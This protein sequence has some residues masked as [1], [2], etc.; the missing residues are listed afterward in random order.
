MQT[1]SKQRNWDPLPVSSDARPPPRL[2]A[3]PCTERWSDHEYNLSWVEPHS[4]C[5][6]HTIR[7]PRKFYLSQPL[8]TSSESR[9][10]SNAAFNICRVHCEACRPCGFAE[11]WQERERDVVCWG[12]KR[13]YFCKPCGSTA[14]LLTLVISAESPTLQHFH[15]PSLLPLKN[16]VFWLDCLKCYILLSELFAYKARAV[17]NSP[18]AVHLWYKRSFL[19]SCGNLLLSKEFAR[20]SSLYRKCLSVTCVLRLSLI[21]S[22]ILEMVLNAGDITVLVCDI[23]R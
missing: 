19:L 16:V 20:N 15:T 14:H 13:R 6:R 3:S 4:Q 21:I 9:R 1:R 12:R 11:L 23:Y 22:P 17:A 2:I 8:A 18:F 7:N 10:A 5:W